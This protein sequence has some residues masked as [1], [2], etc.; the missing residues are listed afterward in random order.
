MCQ[1][2]YEEDASIPVTAWSTPEFGS[3][4][5]RKYVF[6]PA[7]AICYW[8]IACLPWNPAVG[9]LV[10]NVICKRALIVLAVALGATG[11]AAEESSTAIALAEKLKTLDVKVVPA[12]DERF[13]ELTRMLSLDVRAGLQ[14]AN[15][16]ETEAWRKL[17]GREDWEK[18]R[19]AKLVKLRESL[20]QFPSPPQDLHVRLTRTLE[21][22]NFQIENLIYESRPGIFVTANLYSP[23]PT[24]AKM[25][26][27]LICHSHHN[28][29]TQSELQDMGMTWAR[30]GCLV[31]VM[32]QLGHGERRQHSFSNE[33]A[34]PQPFQVGRQDYWFRYNLGMQLHLLGD[35][36]VGWMAWDMMRGVDLLLARP[37]CD[38]DRIVLLG[39]VAG[40]GDPTAV[41]AALDRRIAA[42]APFNFGG[43][44]PET[45]FPLPADAEA[46]F[47]YAGGGSWESTRN[48]RRSAGD[49]FLPW[50]IVGSIAP[51]RLIYAHEFAW[52]YER[53]P[54]WARF[55]KI[56]GWYDVPTRLTSAT[57]R[58]S[59][60]GKAPESTHCNNIG[61]EHRKPIHAALQRWFDM[62]IP[63]EYHQPRSSQDLV[64]WTEEARQ[65][66]KPRT[67]SEVSSDLAEQRVAAARSRVS[68]NAS[69]ERAEE[70]R[71]L[72]RPLLGNRLTDLQAVK[73]TQLNQES[74]P[75]WSESVAVERIVLNVESRIAVPLVLLRPRNNKSVRP[76]VVGLSQ[77]GKERFLQERGAV[78]AEL[79]SQGVAVCLPDV[80]GTGE[81]KPEGNDR[82]RQSA[83]TSYSSTELM[84][85]RTLL[86]GRLRDLQAVLKYV[87]ERKDV[88]AG[89]IA[90]WGDS[91]A[92]A[93]PADR[94]LDVPFDANPFPAIAEPLGG[95]LALFGA[96][97]EPDIRAVYVC[98]GLSG[99]QS[100]L[101]SPYCYIPHDV[102]VPGALTAGDLCDVAAALAPRSVYL[103]EM[104]DGLNRR[105]SVDD[106]RTVYR[107]AIAAYRDASAAEH[108][109]LESASSN[110]IANWF[111]QQLK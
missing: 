92:A 19:D 50:V 51:R 5:G 25:P 1:Y 102:V 22:E 37:G 13:P 41:T 6:S 86:G 9:E 81:T 4:G 54:V 60:K 88:D 17:G 91:F 14:G 27:I 23:V 33:K 2:Y 75:Q 21:G 66:L 78:I 12:G 106:L 40:G 49:G 72:W 79:L 93:N 28:S 70:L 89:R 7:G 73:A 55:E 29:K 109:Q 62:P 108:L 76:L 32:D 111:V 31:L 97:D 59:V 95:L 82:G 68:A 80:R 101:Q 69:N 46:A 104:V 84:L 47:N 99:Y 8:R 105:V 35:S 65:T 63:E 16:R 24:R 74:D 67:L 42:A 83:A 90:L 77:H 43:P 98:S 10:V 3:E 71:Q 58:G 64:C 52:D 39:S 11:L 61:A 110:E 57:G 48:L 20:G 34:Y 103:A 44:Q 100:V 38:A 94:R 36:L 85:D 18:Y 53:D 45:V 15:L 56:F 30:Q 96:L 26:G 107:P 87:R